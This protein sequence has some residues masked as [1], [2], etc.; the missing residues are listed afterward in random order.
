MHDQSVIYK[1]M[2]VGILDQF[3]S[4]FALSKPANRV[5]L[6]RVEIM[7]YV[8]K[9]A[10]RSIDTVKTISNHDIPNPKSPAS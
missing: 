8:K 6:D 9:P 7:I 2:R 10:A 3:S 4:Y 1:L 5:C